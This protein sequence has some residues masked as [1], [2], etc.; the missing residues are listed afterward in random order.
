MRTA[1]RSAPPRPADPF[2]PRRVPSGSAEGSRAVTGSRA[3]WTRSASTT[4]RSA[5]A[6]SRRTC[7]GAPVPPRAPR[8]RRRHPPPL[9]RRD[10]RVCRPPSATSRAG[11]RCSSTTSPPT[12]PRA[13]GADASRAPAGA[14][15]FRR[16]CA[17][18]GSR[19][20]R[21]SRTPRKHGSYLPAQVNSITNSMLRLRIRNEGGVIKVGAPIPLIPHSLSDRGSLL[22]GRYAVRFKI[23]PVPGFK[24]AWLLWPA[25]ENWPQDGEIDFPEGDLD[26]EHQRLHAPAGR[27][28]RLGPGR[29]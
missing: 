9:P 13:D 5:R 29:L 6:R 20:R 15:A 17:T 10:P 24:V 14:R 7:G 3:S 25:S 27:L 22:Y 4:A 28:E 2:R 23:D 19:T 26:G 11:A 12:F 1:M 21:A 8:P 18:S 16:P